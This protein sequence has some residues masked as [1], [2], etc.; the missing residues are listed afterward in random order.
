MKAA[1]LYIKRSKWVKNRGLGHICSNRG[2]NPAMRRP[3]TAPAHPAR[4]RNFS[5]NHIVM[6]D[7]DKKT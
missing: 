4:A 3:K 6:A 5:R 2:P 1:G 7:V